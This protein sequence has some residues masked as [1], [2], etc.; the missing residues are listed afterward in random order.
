MEKRANKGERVMRKGRFTLI[1]LLV[2]IAIIAI[3][4]GMLLPALGKV[5]GTAQGVNC[6]SNLKQL[7][8]VSISYTDD[9]NGVLWTS[10]DGLLF[11]TLYST[12]YLPYGSGTFLCP[13]RYPN[14]FKERYQT[15]AHREFSDL[16]KSIRSRVAT[17]IDWDVFLNV[18]KVKKPAYFL[19]HG[20]S[21]AKAT[22][23]TQNAGSHLCYNS[24]TTS[25]YAVTHGEK[26]NFNFLD[27]HAEGCTVDDFFRNGKV[28]WNEQGLTETLHIFDRVGLLKRKS[29]TAP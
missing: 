27:G 24:D 8:L 10:S 1:E 14:K 22:S 2:V 17:A 3:L 20:D 5:K 9:F 19:L 23:Q 12:G 11:P 15:Y 26:A 29:V 6:L 28:E 25:H 7:S 18:K 4:A 21:R 16:P 13:G